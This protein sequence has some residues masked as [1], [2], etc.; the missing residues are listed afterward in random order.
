MPEQRS[1]KAAVRSG[2]GEWA[3][4]RFGPPP[5]RRFQRTAGTRGVG[6]GL[7]SAFAASPKSGSNDLRA[8]EEAEL[9]EWAIDLSKRDLPPK[10]A[11]TSAK[12]EKSDGAASSKRVPKTRVESF[13][14]A[15]FTVRCE[16]TRVVLRVHDKNIAVSRQN[17]YDELF[18]MVRAH[19]DRH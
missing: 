19:L 17:V 4:A 16:P 14:A 10:K 8:R 6:T 13:G 2:P 3:T 9:L 15:E 11:K 18:E 1:A 5:T 7:G 12:A